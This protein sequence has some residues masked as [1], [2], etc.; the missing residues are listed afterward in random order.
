MGGFADSSA[1]CGVTPQ[2]QKYWKLMCQYFSRIA[3]I[4]ATDVAHA[5]CLWESN[6]YQSPV[7][8]REP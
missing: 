4:G 7:N 3:E 5:D 8:R 6:V 2:A 1:T